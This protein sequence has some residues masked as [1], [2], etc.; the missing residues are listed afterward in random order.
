MN[1]QTRDQARDVA[2]VSSDD[3]Q[4]LLAALQALKRGEAVRLPD[5]DPG[6]TGKIAS[7]FNDV[8]ALNTRWAE[9]V[10][11][12]S[13]VVGKEGKLKQ[14]AMLG[15]GQGFWRVSVESINS[16]IDDLVHP[17]SEVARVIGA[18][19]QGDLTKSMAL[20]V[21]GRELE[22][23]FLR[24]AKTINRMVDQ[25]STFAAEVTRVAREVGTEGKLGGQAKVKGVAGTWKDLDRLG[26]LD[27]RQPHRPGAQHCRCDD[28]GGAGRPVTQ[29]YR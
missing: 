24:T 9:E 12:L 15:D 5:A 4:P 10:S 3:L 25:L 2:H 22:G 20:E 27:G 13:R 18:V 19:A 26:E 8:V 29:D 28:G 23:E 1:L 11:R 6:I 21:E 7:A 14:R 16:L 17:T